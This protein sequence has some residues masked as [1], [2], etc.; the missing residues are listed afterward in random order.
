MVKD[1]IIFA[2]KSAE[3]KKKETGP[4]IPRVLKG[5][6]K[7]LLIRRLREC[8]KK[9]KTVKKQCSDAAGFWFL[10]KGYT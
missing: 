6:F 7:Q 10:L 3:I 1:Y 8:R 9:G 5:R 2:R 4:D